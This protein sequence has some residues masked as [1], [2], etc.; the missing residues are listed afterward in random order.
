M[1]KLDNALNFLQ[2]VRDAAQEE[3]GYGREDYRM[4]MRRALE[5]Q[6][7]EGDS[8]RAQQMLGTNRSIS[9]MRELMHKADPA[10]IKAREQMGLGLKEDRA[11][12]IGQILGTLGSDLVQDRGREIW[13]LINA[14]QAAATVAQD[15]ALK[16][17]A[18]GLF[19]ASPVKDEAGNV[20]SSTQNAQRLGI[21]DD[22]GRPKAGYMK[23]GDEYYKRDH[24]PGHV[25]A[26]NIPAGFAVNTAIGLMT[27][28]GGAE[29]YKAVFEDEDDPSKSSNP[30]ME[31]A[32]KYVLG[33]TGGLLPWEEF[34]KVRP[35]VSKDEYMR[36]KAFK[37]DN[38]TDLNPLDGDFSLPTGVLKGTT[39]GIHGPE[40]QFLGRSLPLHTAIMPTAASIA[41]TTYGARRGGV[42]GGLIGGALS[43]AAGMLGG[44]IIEQE[45]RRRNAAENER[46]RIDTINQYGVI[47]CVL[48]V[49]KQK[50]S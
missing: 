28:F 26:L 13:W 40:I 38:E 20:I 39:E 37:F 8:T 34:K 17:H 3:M 10:H 5:D 48:Q 49:A 19:K 11:G 29:G 1:S 24:E 30:V 21:V 25:E 14:P 22:V 35:D 15:L 31:V 6:G 23:K 32:A 2:R 41:G 46:D 9:L 45:R 50:T 36:Y 43:T 33:R 42:K 7:I 16:K 27:P 12:K 44:N 18:P 47:T 4:A